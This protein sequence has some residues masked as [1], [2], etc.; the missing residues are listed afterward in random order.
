M[1]K[2]FF[3]G[4]FVLFLILLSGV[5]EAFV[6]QTP[7]LLNLVVKKIKQPVGIEVYQNKKILNYKDTQKGV[8]QLKE[9]LIYR[10]PNRF[11]SE[12]ISD[13]MT[14]FSVES[15]FECIKVMNGVIIS[16]DKPLLDM[17]TDILLYRN[18]ETLLKQLVLAG[19]DIDK[20][21]FQRFNDTVCYVIGRPLTKGE[22]FAGLWIEKESFLPV[23]Y[24]VE[25]NGWL[26]EFFYSNWQ[27]V[28]K[29]WYPKQVYIF[30]DNQLFATIEVNEIDLKSNFSLSLFDID[31][32]KRLYPK[33]EPDS[34]DENSRQVDDLDRRIENF[35]KLYE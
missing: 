23:Q 14:S 26:V 18:H 29:T 20:V 12:I 6:P 16:N 9:R 31:H 19:I 1:K 33:N 2:R 4:F 13:A 22:P 32:I 3:V 21:S 35:K 5:G 30:L 7:H 27:Q 10:Y 25:K 17:Y 11:R 28:S 34:L 8:Q 24:V 15:D